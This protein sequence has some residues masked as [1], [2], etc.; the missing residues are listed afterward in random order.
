MTEVELLAQQASAGSLLWSLLQYWTGVSMGVLIAAHLAAS[1]L[2][3]VIIAILLVVY[4]TFTFSIV[5]LV[6][7]NIEMIRGTILDIQSLS[8]QGIALGRPAQALLEYAPVTNQTWLGRTASLVMFLGMFLITC[9][10]PIS[11]KLKAGK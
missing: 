4:I 11:V 1:R 2:S 9:V 10:Y 7:L 5:G 6:R 3:W 8:D